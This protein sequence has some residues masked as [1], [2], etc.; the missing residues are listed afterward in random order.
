[1]QN[2]LIYTDGACEPNPG[3]GGWAAIIQFKLKNDRIYEKE[4][5]G[6]N[7]YTTNNRMEITGVTEALKL[8]TKPCRVTVFSDSKYV[9]NSIGWWADGEPCKN[10]GWIINWKKY[11]WRRKDGELQNIDLWKEVYDLV[12]LHKSLQ[13][14]WVRGHAGHDLNERCDRLAVQARKMIID[15]TV[16]NRLRQ[17]QNIFHKNQ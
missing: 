8:I 11:G 3:I 5:F 13:M 10:H 16:G 2:I 7:P 17:P 9:V 4:I 14:K 12:R 15:D 1:M 6:S